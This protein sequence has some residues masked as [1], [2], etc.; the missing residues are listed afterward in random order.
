MSGVQ[1]ITVGTDEADQRLDRW[2]RRHYPHVAQGRIE[3]MCRKG[4]IRVDGGRVKA[5]D[6]ARGRADGA[7][8][9]DPRGARRRRRPRRGVVRGRRRDDPRLRHLARRRHH[10]AQ[11]AARPRGAGRL[12]PAPPRRRAGRGAA[13]ST[14]PTS[15]ASCTAS[16]ATPRACCSSPAPPGRRRAW[17]GRSRRARRARSTGRPS[18]ARPRRA[19]GTIR[20]GLV[21][22]P[23]HGAGGEG[24][25]ML[26]VPP[27]QVAATEGAKRATTDYAVIDAAATR[28]A[29]VALS[30]VTGRTHQ[31]RAHMAAIG[32]PVVGDGK[33]GGSGQE[34]LGEGW[35]AQLGG[36]VSRKLHLHARSLA[37]DPPGDRQA[38]HPDRAAPRAHGAHL[39][40]L[41]LAARGRRRRSLRGPPVSPPPGSWRCP[42]AAT[43]SPSRPGS[44]TAAA[45]SPPAP[46]TRW[47]PCERTGRCA[48]AGWR[49]AAI[50]RCHPWGG[51]GI[52]NV[53]QNRHARRRS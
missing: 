9:A 37:L 49:S 20:Y 12:G 53:P 17:R 4:E 30:P 43:G 46:P 27:D 29:W 10:R 25:K 19:A 51:S 28:A 22:A 3:R 42:S 8:A 32:H 35:G 39:G 18:P 47:R 13:G 33:Y 23:G 50:L 21:K 34:N 41:R 14:G 15:R 16:T 31:L 7:R 44:A 26:C 2:L 40:P 52:D 1:Q 5:G 45:S 48:A 36:G 24:E 38:P 11:Q 6:P